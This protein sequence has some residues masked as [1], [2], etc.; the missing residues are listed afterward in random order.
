MD[1]EDSWYTITPGIVHQGRAAM[2]GS[3][4]VSTVAVHSFPGSQDDGMYT[5]N[6][7]SSFWDS[8]FISAASR[9]ALKTLSQKL[10]VFSGNNKNP[11]SFPYYAPRPDFFVDNMISPGYFKDRF[12]DTFGPVAC[13][14]EHC[15]INFSVFLFFKLSIDVVVIVIRH[16]EIIKLTGASLGFGRTLL[17]ASYN[18]FL[19]SVLTSRIDPHA[20]LLLPQLDY[21]S[22]FPSLKT[23]SLKLQKNFFHLVHFCRMFDPFFHVPTNSNSDHS[24]LG[25]QHRR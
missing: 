25:R 3:K 23:I 21:S 22:Q 8:I 7:L 5:R 11:D 15:G 2:L 24:I 17:N 20:S 9:N 10:I 12:M 16:L 19:M 14:L 13:I 4:D 1:H 18:I 6:E